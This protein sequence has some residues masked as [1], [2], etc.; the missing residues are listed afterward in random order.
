MTALANWNS[1][2]DNCIDFDNITLIELVLKEHRNQV[3][4]GKAAKSVYFIFMYVFAFC[5]ICV[6]LN[7][8][9]YA[10]PVRCPE[11]HQKV[12]MK[13]H[14]LNLTLCYDIFIPS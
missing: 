13:L 12:E 8:N 14:V 1:F 9:F 10:H 6:D 4:L 3:P 2:R 7:F 5:H 11:L